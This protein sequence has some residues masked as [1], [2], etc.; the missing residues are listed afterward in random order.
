MD[1][2]YMD[3]LGSDGVTPASPKVL[4]EKSDNCHPFRYANNVGQLVIITLVT[5]AEFSVVIVCCQY[6][7]NHSEDDWRA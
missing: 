6:L 4:S 1:Q 5:F 3:Q 7:P 2:E